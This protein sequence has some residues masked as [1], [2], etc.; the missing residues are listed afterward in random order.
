MSD[1]SPH[2]AQSGF[3]DFVE[4]IPPSPKEIHLVHGEIK[5]NTG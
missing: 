2:A 1:Y 5:R 3:L 4:G